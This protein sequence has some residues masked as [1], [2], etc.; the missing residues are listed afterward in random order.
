MFQVRGPTMVDRSWNEATMKVSTWQKDMRLIGDAL[1]ATETPAPL[2]AS[3]V[4]IYNAAMALG[5]GMDDTAAVYAVLERM[6]G[7]P[8]TPKKPG[9]RV[10]KA[11]RSRA[12]RSLSCPCAGWLACLPEP[13]VSG[14]R[15]FFAAMHPASQRRLQAGADTSSLHLPESCRPGN[16]HA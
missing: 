2:F 6:V 15:H 8:V 5:H 13:S 16:R 10:R 11:S 7:A 14:R 1:E 9:A 3:C 12:F 4:P